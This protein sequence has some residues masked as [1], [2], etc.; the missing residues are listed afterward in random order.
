[1]SLKAQVMN[2][3][4]AAARALRIGE[5][6]EAIAAALFVGRHRVWVTEETA[7]TGKRRSLIEDNPCSG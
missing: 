3:H 1:M 5:K 4:I 6:R 2:A 7:R